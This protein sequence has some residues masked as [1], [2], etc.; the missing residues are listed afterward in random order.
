LENFNIVVE[1]IKKYIPQP[2]VVS[3]V[4]LSQVSN[5]PI[6]APPNKKFMPP[7]IFYVQEF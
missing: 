6:V 2:I 4:L 5:V 3:N 7:P 1:A